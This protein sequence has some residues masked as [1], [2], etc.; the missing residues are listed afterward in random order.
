MKT[1]LRI[2]RQGKT[3]VTTPGL[4]RLVRKA[5]EETLSC[6]AIEEATEIS[7]LLTDDQTIHQLNYAYRDKDAPTDVL[8]FAMEEGEEF[9]A[10]KGEPR[11]LGDIVISRQRAAEQA[12]LYGHSQEREE[13]FLF[14]HG[15]LHLLGYD[16]ERSKEEEREMFALQDQII[17]RLS[18]RFPEYNLAV[19]K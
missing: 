17:A 8:S 18:E 1:K 13:V 14:I 12:Q 2:T 7:L 9:V 10:T 6:L 16:H 5:A 4:R 3:P 15:L 19:S 11:M